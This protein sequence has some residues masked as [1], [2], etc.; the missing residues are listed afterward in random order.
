MNGTVIGRRQP[1]LGKLLPRS[2]MSLTALISLHC[3]LQ[4]Q[5]EELTS[6]FAFAV[7]REICQLIQLSET[8]LEQALCSR[9][10]EAHQEKL[11]TTLTVSQVSVELRYVQISSRSLVSVQ[12][13]WF[14]CISIPFFL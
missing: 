5:G 9:T 1:E 7:V 2:P 13:C 3:I 11:V 14:C 8:A 10:V 12:E 6:R 4:Y